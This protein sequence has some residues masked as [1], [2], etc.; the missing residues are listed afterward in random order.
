MKKNALF[1]IVCSTISRYK[2]LTIDI[3]IKDRKIKSKSKKQKESVKCENNNYN[4]GSKISA[5]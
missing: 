5:I 2:G 1:L 4:R 3:D